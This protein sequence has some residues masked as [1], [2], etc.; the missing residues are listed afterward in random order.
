MPQRDCAPRQ[1]RGLPI[2]PGGFGGLLAAAMAKG[3]Q[4]IWMEQDGAMLTAPVERPK[5]PFGR[6]SRH[7]MRERNLPSNNYRDC[8]ERSSRGRANAKV[9]NPVGSVYVAITCHR[10]SL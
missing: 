7:P 9:R 10:G 6:P 1:D 5:P 4:D 3:Q 8:R 2:A